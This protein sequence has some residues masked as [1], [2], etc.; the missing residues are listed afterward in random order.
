M[1][2]LSIP[3]RREHTFTFYRGPAILLAEV[4][5][6][7]KVS[8]II[9]CTHVPYINCHLCYMLSAFGCYRAPLPS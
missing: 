1:I 2:R 8:I 4:Y 7:G 6:G 3:Y 9:F 5:Y